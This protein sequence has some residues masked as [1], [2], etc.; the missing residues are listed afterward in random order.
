MDQPRIRR[1]LTNRL[2]G[3][4]TSLAPE[5]FQLSCGCGETVSGVRQP[6]HQILGCPRCQQPLFVLPRSPL[7]PLRD[8]TGTPATVTAPVP[9][10]LLGGL[11]LTGILVSGALLTW[12]KPWRGFSDQVSAGSNAKVLDQTA[13]QEQLSATRAALRR[14]HYQAAVEMLDGVRPTRESLPAGDVQA[15]QYDQL[16]KQVGLLLD[17]SSESLGEMI[18]RLSPLEERE[19]VAFW[20]RR[21]RHKTVIFD[22]AVR[23]DAAGQ[24]HLSY[25]VSVGA[26]PVQVDLDGLRLLHVLALDQPNRLIFG[27]RLASIQREPPGRWVVHFEPDSAVLF[28]DEA[29]LEAICLAATDKDTNDV[30]ARQR[31]WLQELP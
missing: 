26:D 2:P 4:G 22:A 23:R 12:Y 16:T 17:L 24:L 5:P 15:R 14:G 29:A 20:Q 7:P 9:V 1:W 10:W 3:W 28:T 11:V 19:R 25:N 6:R 18:D 21:F 30:L 27:A 13:M 31:A 8:E